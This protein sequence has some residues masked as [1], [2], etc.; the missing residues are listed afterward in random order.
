MR[1]VL[2]PSGG[3]IDVKWFQIKEYLKVWMKSCVNIDE[4]QTTPPVEVPE[5]FWHLWLGVL[6]EM[7]LLGGSGWRDYAGDFDSLLCRGCEKSMKTLSFRVYRSTDCTV[8]RKF[9]I[10]IY[11]FRCCDSSN[12]LLFV[13][14]WPTWFR[15]SALPG[16][17]QSSH[18][19]MLGKFTG[20]NLYSFV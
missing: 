7:C 17:G 9:R 1:D 16:L 19:L 10:N 5:C 13:L 14:L 12:L 20:E 11:F 2:K 4:R 3:V 15:V 8:W 6:A 18:H